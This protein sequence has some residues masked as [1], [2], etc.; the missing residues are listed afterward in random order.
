MR[1]L[2]LFLALALMVLSF[3][4]LAD[5]FDS[6]CSTD[7]DCP[8][9]QQCIHVPCAVPEC[10][11]GEEC[12][13]PGECPEMGYCEEGYDDDYGDI[14]IWGGEC[15]TDAD[16]PEM[17]ICE[18]KVLPCASEEIF[19]GDCACDCDPDDPDCVCE[20]PPCPEPEPCDPEEMSV[21][22]LHLPDCEVDADCGE[23]FI[24]ETIEE[25]W[26]SGGGSSGCACPPSTCV[27]DCDPDDPD[28]ECDCPEPEPCDCED[29]P[30]PEPEYEEGCD[31]VGHVCVPDEIE[32]EADAD[33]PTDFTCEDVG[34][35]SGGGGDCACM[36]CPAPPPP[37]CADDDEA[38]WEA[39]KEAMDDYECPPCEC[40]DEPEEPEAVMMCLPDGWGEILDDWVEH[41]G[42]FDGGGGGT[43]ES[44][45]PWVSDDKQ[46]G[47]EGEQAP[48][49]PNGGEIGTGEGTGGGGSGGDGSGRSADSGDDGG[50][51]CSYGS[52]AP[53]LGGLVVLMGLI[54]GWLVI[55][56]RRGV[57]G[58]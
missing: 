23:G 53:A 31:V 35:Y 17:F 12:P 44:G 52:R 19:C 41:G 51:L 36:T 40:D 7:A 37:D 48:S 54:A 24:C 47:G 30:E 28:C 1:S 27:C 15:E 6:E 10:P 11:P 9:G 21:C 2:R 20:C 5:E 50:A 43:A 39:W 14:G 55:V 34:G 58:L 16:C 3:G 45:S 18:V 29:D 8:E 4:A 25:C 46:E 33:C 56:R 26:A 49:D 22:V 57:I 32:C 13:D 42:D 38:C